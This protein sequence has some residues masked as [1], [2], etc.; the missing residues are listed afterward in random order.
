M[1]IDLEMWCY[2]CLEYDYVT[3]LKCVASDLLLTL[4][5]TIKNKPDFCAVIQSDKS[6]FKPQEEQVASICK[7]IARDRNKPLGSP[8]PL[9]FFHLMPQFFISQVQH[10]ENEFGRMAGLQIKE[11]CDK[12]DSITGPQQAPSLKAASTLLSANLVDTLH[13]PKCKLQIDTQVYLCINDWVSSHCKSYEENSIIK[14]NDQ[15]RTHTD[16]LALL[17]EKSI[18]EL[19]CP[20]CSILVFPPTYSCASCRIFFHKS[21]AEVLFTYQSFGGH[22]FSLIAPPFPN[23]LS[24]CTHCKNPITG[25]AY[26]CPT[27]EIIIDMQCALGAPKIRNIN[28]KHHLF[29]WHSNKSDDD[30]TCQACESYIDEGKVYFRCEDI[31]CRFYLHVECALLPPIIKHRIHQ[32][33]LE[34][35]EDLDELSDEYI[36]DACELDLNGLLWAYRCVDSCKGYATSHVTCVIESKKKC[37]FMYEEEC[38]VLSDEERARARARGIRGI[39]RQ[40]IRPLQGK[41]LLQTRMKIEDE[42][43]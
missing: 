30:I 16:P 8:R 1:E 4:R 37:N 38:R 22:T 42:G 2:C 35:A 41:Q 25:Y 43:L 5:S 28:H 21:C 11:G 32:H 24:N 23:S 7:F 12:N 17:D 34:L 27:C 26:L 19:Y 36:C 9:Y 40:R 13:C 39:R 3:H 14:I 18:D 10:R 33:P 29:C 6:S 20:I 31:A 15:T